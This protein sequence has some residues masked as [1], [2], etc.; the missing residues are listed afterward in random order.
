MIHDNHIYIL[1]DPG[2]AECF[3]LETGKLVW[4]ERLK[5]PGPK[6][7][8]WSS[9]VLADQKLYAINQGGDAFVL[10]ASPKFQ[11]LSTNSLGEHTIASMALS[12]GQIFIRTYNNLWCIGER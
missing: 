2:V 7:D 9:I 11:V 4:E 3:E 1:N 12:D 8:N 10:N 6:S 5:G